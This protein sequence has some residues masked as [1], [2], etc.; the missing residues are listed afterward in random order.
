MFRKWNYDQ[1]VKVADK[2]M[3]LGNLIFI[4]LVVSQVFSGQKFNP[5]IAVLG[6][7]IIIIA[8][9]VAIWL[10]KGGRKL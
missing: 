1:K 7:F 5:V 4:G 8:Y 6:F 2:I 10:L 3:E 9:A